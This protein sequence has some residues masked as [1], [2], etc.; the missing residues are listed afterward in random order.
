[1]VD[2][3]KLKPLKNQ[4]GQALFELI[5]FIPFLIFL[6]TIYSTTGDS[7]SAS[8][9]QQKSVRGY[10]Y[11]LVMGN[12]Y[13]N[14][15]LELAEFA[16]FNVTLVGFSAL[17]WRE[18]GN[19][20]GTTAFAPCF[21]FSSLLKNNS[22]EECD[23]KEREDEGMSRYIRVFTYYGVCGPVYTAPV[24]EGSLKHWINPSTQSDPYKCSLGAS[25]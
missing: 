13:L 7:I 15:P 21:K 2:N 24:G 20:N 23:S 11:S 10:F 19:A 5:I 3:K 6:Y 18:K 12:S 14:N 8:I 22:S 16:R 25:N 1:M 4:S 9:N 17:G